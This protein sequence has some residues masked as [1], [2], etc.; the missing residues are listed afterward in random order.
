MEIINKSSQLLEI[1]P[2][3]KIKRRIGDLP[4]LTCNIQKS[5]KKLK[6]YPKNSTLKKIIIDEIKWQKYLRQKNI[7]ELF[8]TNF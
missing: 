4:I 2:L 3:I 8:I 7:K 1:K 5:K 6:W